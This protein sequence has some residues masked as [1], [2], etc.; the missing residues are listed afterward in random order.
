MTNLAISEKSSLLAKLSTILTGAKRDYA[1]SQM[2]TILFLFAFSM[3]D[4]LFSIHYNLVSDAII[5]TFICLLQAV[6]ILVF[7][8]NKN[9][10]FNPQNV[11][12]LTTVAIF[13]MS[14]PGGFS[15]GSYFY[16]FP[17]AMVYF[18]G[19]SNTNNNKR[20]HYATGIDHSIFTGLKRK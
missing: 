12:F 13:C 14:L 18:L 7:R 10:L 5:I 6:T 16:Y 19:T 3:M 4:I 17:A 11:F 1:I 9:R 2:L 15:T 20:D 8:N